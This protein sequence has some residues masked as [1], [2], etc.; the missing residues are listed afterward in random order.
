MRVAD[1]WRGPLAFQIVI[2]FDASALA[3]GIFFARVTD[4]IDRMT[5]ATAKMMLL[6]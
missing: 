1:L 2:T 4:V 6:K 3:C 5:M